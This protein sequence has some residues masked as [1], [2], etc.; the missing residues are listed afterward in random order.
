MARKSRSEWRELV[1]EWQRSGLP[2]G[3]FARARGLNATTL[4]WWR[5][6][7]GV[8]AVQQA[9][10]FL[11]VVVEEET[12]SPAPPSFVLEL[13]ELRLHVPCGFDGGELRRLVATLC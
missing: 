8:P 9:T 4:G 12:V 2:R 1:E 3:E 13:G 11:E 6:K 7:L 5:W 10:S